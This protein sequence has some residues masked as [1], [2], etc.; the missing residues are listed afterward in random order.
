[1]VWFQ[2]LL[3]GVWLWWP[4]VYAWPDHQGALVAQVADRGCVGQEVFVAGGGEPGPVMFV[5]ARSSPIQAMT[6][7]HIS[8]STILGPNNRVS[9]RQLLFFRSSPKNTSLPCSSTISV[10]RPR[11]GASLLRRRGR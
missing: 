2:A 7:G 4:G 8:R 3:A 6:S 5:L 9:T 11:S 10:S 1:M